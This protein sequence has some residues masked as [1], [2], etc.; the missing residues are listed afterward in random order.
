MGSIL[1]R[2]A[3]NYFYGAM[4]WLYVGK[5]VKRCT[6]IIRFK[7][8]RIDT[9]RSAAGNSNFVL[10]VKV[11]IQRTVATIDKTDRERTAFPIYTYFPMQ[12]MDVADS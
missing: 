8:Y 6:K 10:A 5:S 3:A 1:G 12:H 4:I 2:I 9:I 7:L 11:W